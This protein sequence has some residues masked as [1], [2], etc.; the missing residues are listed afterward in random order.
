MNLK[1][2]SDKDL[3]LKTEN[4]VKKERELFSEILHHL[5]E[6]QRRRLYAD[7]GYRSLWDYCM[8][9]LGFCESQTRRTTDALKLIQE[10][11][12]V[13]KLVEKG[14]LSLSNIVQAQT[15]FRAEEKVGAALNPKEKLEVLENL[16]N[17]SAREGLLAHK[18]PNMKTSQL[19]KVVFKMVLGNLDPARKT[20]RE[21]EKENVPN[22]LPPTSAV[23]KQA[24]GRKYIS[25]KTVRKVWKRADSKCENCNSHFALEIDHVIPVSL[26]GTSERENL[27]MLCRKCNQRA[28]IT[29]LGQAQMDKYLT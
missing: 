19:M 14:E 23:K 25:V 15:H 22:N 9:H 2:L 27:R 29:I 6:I 8:R 5:H 3:L 16:K 13:E 20:E 10:I 18:H 26:G 11:P 24:T 7:L 17:K 12:E 21:K 28:A 4:L 1:N